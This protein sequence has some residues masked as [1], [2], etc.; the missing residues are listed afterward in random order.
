[1]MG[2]IQ[3]AMG[4]AWCAMLLAVL[5]L[6][7][8]H[9]D[10]DKPKD[11]GLNL[12]ARSLIGAKCA[13]LAI[14]FAAPFLGTIFPYFFRKS[15]S[16]LLLGTQFAGGVFLSSALMHFLSDS[17]VTFKQL[18]PA[19]NYSLAAMFA[20]VGYL[21]TMLADVLVHRVYN[22]RA[23]Q[24][25]RKEDLENATEGPETKAAI[26][27]TMNLFDL[28]LL[29]LTLCF[30]SVFDGLAVGVTATPREAWKE[31]WRV[32]LHKSIMGIGL[33]IVVLRLASTRRLLNSLVYGFAFSISTSVGIAIGILLDSTN[34]G[35]SADWIFAVWMGIGTGVFIYV[36]INHLLAW[37]NHKLLHKEQALF[38]WL[39]VLFG[40]IATAVILIWD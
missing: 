1:M 15:N 40:F 2:R 25:L 28:L 32:G 39:A 3:G 5:E 4:V 24:Q 11:A 27:K 12:R 14:D 34:W 38:R 26:L 10:P 9:T 35:S 37:D 29:T 7:E 30:H 20:V 18:L 13:A 33:G 6:C 22:H 17:N 23:F 8:S 16:F 21:L 36:V 19:V 31:M